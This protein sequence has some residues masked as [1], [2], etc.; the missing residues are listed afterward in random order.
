MA[1]K[2]WDATEIF[3][4]F[5]SKVSPQENLKDEIDFAK[6]RDMI[7]S[8]SIEDCGKCDVYIDDIV[9][10]CVD[11]TNNV[12]R[13]VA[14][15]CTV[16]HAIAHKGSGATYLPRDDMIAEDKC[17]AEGAPALVKTC[18]GWILNTR[19]L[20]VNLPIHK[21]IAWD[22]DLKN[23]INRNSISHTELNSLIR[24]L[25]NVIVILK[26]MEHYMNNLYDFENLII[27]LSAMLANT[28]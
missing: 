19:S 4:E 5:V 23:L 6:A 2:N 10:I 16:I 1:C 11:I 13:I 9:P 17:D 18:L 28:D 21:Y 27:L 7:I 14:A 12:D 22:L 25:E 20:S 26:I 3:S 8:L 24:K 15:P